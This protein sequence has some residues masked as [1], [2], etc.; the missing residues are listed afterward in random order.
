MP[1]KLKIHKVNS[2]PIGGDVLGNSIYLVPSGNE[3]VDLYVSNI[4]GTQIKRIVSIS[5]IPTD[6]QSTENI[7]QELLIKSESTYPSTKAVMDAIESIGGGT[8]L[9]I[10]EDLDAYNESLSTIDPVVPSGI[11]FQDGVMSY[12][13]Q[14]EANPIITHLIVDLPPS[15]FIS[16]EQIEKSVIFNIDPDASGSPNTVYSIPDLSKFKFKPSGV[17]EGTDRNITLSMQIVQYDKNLITDYGSYGQIA[18]ASQN[19]QFILSIEIKTFDVNSPNFYRVKF[20]ISNSVYESVFESSFVVGIDDVD[21]LDFKIENNTIISNKIPDIA[22]NFA[23]FGIVADDKDLLAIF[24]LFAM[25]TNDPNPYRFELEPFS[26][27]P[28]QHIKYDYPTSARFSANTYSNLVMFISESNVIDDRVEFYLYLSN[29]I[30]GLA[31][32]DYNNYFEL[33]AQYIDLENNVFVEIDG[34]DIKLLNHNSSQYELLYTIANEAPVHFNN[35]YTEYYPDDDTATLVFN[36]DHFDELTQGDAILPEN[37]ADGKEYRITRGGVYK[38]YQLKTGDY[39]KLYNSLNNMIITRNSNFN[40]PMLEAGDEP[41]SANNI[42][43]YLT[44]TYPNVLMNNVKGGSLDIVNNKLEV[45]L[46]PEIGNGT[47]IQ[48]D[49]LFTDFNNIEARVIS[50]EFAYCSYNATLDISRNNV[51]VFNDVYSVDLYNIENS[52]KTQNR[53]N[54]IVL[55]II[56]SSAAYAISWPSQFKWVNDTPP[57]LSSDKLTVITGIYTWDVGNSYSGTFGKVL[58]NVVHYN[59]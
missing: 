5:D 35:A 4:D 47:K 19:T 15:P 49:G 53:Y 21:S 7:V 14:A 45:K 27:R 39:I 54:S 17:T 24:S 29:D 59:K 16:V 18:N 36:I 9:F 48:S 8:G 12:G 34:K 28:K 26:S 55:T 22:Y 25:P 41:T 58:C 6:Y 30:F 50:E 20:G 57:E 40:K 38:N 11:L 3:Y 46:S 51:F 1:N 31:Y 32:G 37:A 10:V 44:D 43:N 33:A 23:D 42:I 2:I 13:E 56:V 52:V